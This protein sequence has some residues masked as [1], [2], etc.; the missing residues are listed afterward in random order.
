MILHWH[1]HDISTLR[2]ALS[3]SER[4]AVRSALLVVG[5]YCCR[6]PGERAYNDTC[7]E[8]VSKYEFLKDN[9]TVNGSNYVSCTVY[10]M[11]HSRWFCI[12]CVTYTCY[13]E[14]NCLYSVHDLANHHLVFVVCGGVEISVIDTTADFRGKCCQILRVS[15]Q[16]SGTCSTKL[17]NCHGSPKQQHIQYL[18]SKIYRKW[19]D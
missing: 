9:H 11:H 10:S 14:S 8:L 1:D 19:L 2:F 7:R 12:I 3:V 4:C 16:K 18:L 15:S 13:Q 5:C 6:Y 17:S